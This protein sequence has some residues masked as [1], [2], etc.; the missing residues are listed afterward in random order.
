M[1]WIILMLATFGVLTGSARAQPPAQG[2]LV[3]LADFPSAHVAPRTVT[4][5]LPPG[6]DA[7]KSR[8]PV[9]YMHDGQNLFDAKSANFGVE[10]GMDEAVDRLSVRGTVRPAIIVGMA[11]T[12]A[13]YHEYMPRKVY[14][15]LPP[16]YAQA[17]RD[18]QK[19][20][21]VSD[22]YLRFIVEDMKPY[23][24]RHFRTRKGPADTAIMGSSMGGLISI[25]ALGEYPGV[26]GSAAALSVHWPLVAA[27]AAAKAGA[28]APGQV[29]AAFAAWLKGTRIDP[30][31]NR[32]YMDHGTATLDQHYAPFRAAI[33][34]MLP[35]LGW[36]AGPH[37][38]SR[39]FTGTAHNEQAWSERVDIPLAFLLG[40][41]KDR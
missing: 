38:E 17:V 34:A 35:T 7:G 23:V 4:I 25:Y 37:W 13:R 12:P 14:D 9:I 40:P 8:Y 19:G 27:D 3:T 5:W 2:R 39:V 41:P 1:R 36:Q 6:Y 29:A 31:R 10:W 32:L 16:A 30:K 20:A 26:F 11:S 28:D 18:T 33:D 22:A 21:P 24:D 15:L